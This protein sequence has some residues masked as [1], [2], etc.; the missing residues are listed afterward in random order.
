[1]KNMLPRHMDER[2]LSETTREACDAESLRL[3]HQLKSPG[4]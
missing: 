2:V 4:L 3:T 1:M